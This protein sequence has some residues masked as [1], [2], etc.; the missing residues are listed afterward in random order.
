M[1]LQVIQA[2]DSLTHIELVGHLDLEGVDAIQDQ[3]VFHTATRRTPAL[4][5][6]EQVGIHGVIPITADVAEARNLLA[7][8]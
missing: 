6:L 3:F 7:G 5:D 1:Q 8:E 2:D 4:I